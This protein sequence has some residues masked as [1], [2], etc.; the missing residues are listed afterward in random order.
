MIKDGGRL[1]LY[2]EGMKEATSGL[3]IKL[4]NGE[5]ECQFA[6]TITL[7]QEAYTKKPRLVLLG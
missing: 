5:W 2:S 1:R 3:T 7:R 6:S 4:Q